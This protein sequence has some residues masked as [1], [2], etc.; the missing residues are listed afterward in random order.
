MAEGVNFEDLVACHYGPLYQFAYSLTRDEADACD[1]T[2]Q[3]FCIWAA[4]G[5]QLRD[6]SKVK[7]W[8]FTTL[9]RE[10]LGSRRRE[11]RFPHVELE[12]AAAELP[13]V[14]PASVH[15]LDSGQ[16]LDALG[17]LDEI[18]RAA[19]VLFYLQDYTYNEI[20]EILEIPLG[21]VKSRLTRG[22]ARL[23]HLLTHVRPPLKP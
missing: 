14:S 17:Q 10:F 1:L 22:L 9:H 16:L 4:K 15:Q 18:Y 23:H 7:T 12:Q 19:V 20:A 21:T 2:Q 13:T 11:A 5:H 8:L 3:T 6:V